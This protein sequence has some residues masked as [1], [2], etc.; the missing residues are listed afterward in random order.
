MNSITL[1]NLGKTS[2]EI[3]EAYKALRTNLEFCGNDVKVIAL[4]SCMSNEGKSSV[5]MNLAYSFAQL[6]KSVLF[7]DA[8]LRKSVITNRY[9]VVGIQKGLAHYLA[10]QCAFSDVVC[11]TNVEHLHCVFA[12]VY[13]PN[14]A[15]LL[16]SS[17]FSHLLTSLRK[18]YDYVIIDAPPL[19][20]VIDAA[21]IA[22]ECDGVAMVVEANRISRKFVN[23][24]LG[25]LRKT[26]CRIL[27]VILNKVVNT[28]GVYA[29][30]YGDYGQY[31]N[32]LS[33][34]RANKPSPGKNN[35]QTTK[36]TGKTAGRR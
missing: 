14:P 16:S 34:A 1:K 17:Y 11:T 13:P 23:H 29:K 30:Y 6:G 31:H 5:S 8:D 19:G 2:F 35:R 20:S 36:N 15:E 21:I 18:V 9:G 33:E 4:T 32:S 25:Q 22:K 28:G 26:D 27:G 24:V 10:G 12:G 7:I 3:N